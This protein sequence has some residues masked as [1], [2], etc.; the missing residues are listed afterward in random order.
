[1]RSAEERLSLSLVPTG[2]RSAHLP[3]FYCLL[4]FLDMTP[5]FSIYSC[6]GEYMF[7]KNLICLYI[8]NWV[9]RINT[10]QNS[11]TI[12][13]DLIVMKQFG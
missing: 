6:L 3:L 2:L 10:L 8:L 1:M 9:E 5:D 12:S 7:M 11:Y 13:L 4:G